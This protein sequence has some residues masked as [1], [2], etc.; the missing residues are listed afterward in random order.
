[1]GKSEIQT[2]TRTSA[3]GAAMAEAYKKTPTM[4]VCSLAFFTG[5][6]RMVRLDDRSRMSREAHVRFWEGVGV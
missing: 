4:A 3:R 2:L 6:L 5:V 1:V